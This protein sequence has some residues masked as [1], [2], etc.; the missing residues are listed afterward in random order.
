V[1]A[2]N[3]RIVYASGSGWGQDGPLADRP[4]MDIMAQAR[5]GLMSITGSPD[6]APAKVGVPIADLVSGLYIAL[7]VT[8]ALRERER[9]GTGQYLDVS[10]LESAASLAI[11]EAARY[12]VTG[13]V[14][15]RLGTAHQSEAPYQA[16]RTSD[17]WVTIAG[18]T[19]KTW[20][21]LCEAIGAVSLC[22]DPRFATSSSRFESRT[23]LIPLI[24]EQ[25]VKYTTADLTERLERAG[26]PC[27]PIADYGDVFTSAHLIERDYFWDA[28]S[29]SVG[30]VRQLGSPMR[31]SRTRPRRDN[32]GP[33]LGA[34]TRTI[35]REAGLSDAEVADLVAAGIAVVQP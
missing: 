6:G 5:G 7:G 20:A 23:T 34:D 28:A 14:G 19:P 30:A 17:G 27:A 3:P 1:R 10:L 15:T 22:D 29:P 12:F 9:S 2:V 21:A 33:S 16:V 31:L 35:L 24:E 11:W 13:D 26:V 25:T 32:A 4:G 8:A 18:V